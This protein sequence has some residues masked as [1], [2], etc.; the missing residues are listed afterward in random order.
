MAL[1][2]H[3][4]LVSEYALCICII[5]RQGCIK[6]LGKGL[7]TY[8]AFLLHPHRQIMPQN[9]PYPELVIY[10]QYMAWDGGNMEEVTYGC[11]REL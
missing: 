10:P 3:W 7:Y 5:L 4:C 8:K 1:D 6:I 2:N 11:L 9:S